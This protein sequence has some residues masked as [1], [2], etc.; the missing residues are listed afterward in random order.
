M[1][2]V[3]GLNIIEEIVKRQNK[4]VSSTRSR[5]RNSKSDGTNMG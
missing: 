1:T 4:S 2:K 3:T 5:Q